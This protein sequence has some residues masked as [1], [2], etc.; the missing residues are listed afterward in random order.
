M[1]ALWWM[2]CWRFHVVVF[3]NRD[4]AIHE[5]RIPSTA[6]FLNF[7]HFLKTPLLGEATTT[8]QTR[9]INGLVDCQHFRKDRSD[10]NPSNHFES[11]S[12]RNLY[13]VESKKYRKTLISVLKRFVGSTADTAADWFFV[14]SIYE[15]ED[16]DEE[17]GD[18]ER[19]RLPLYA[20]AVLGLFT[21][22]LSCYI[23]VMRILQRGESTL[24]K[25]RRWLERFETVC[26]DLPQFVLT[27]MIAAEQGRLTGFAVFNLT[28]SALNFFFGIL[29][30]IEDRLIVEPGDE[31]PYL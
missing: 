6:P 21:F 25:K 5:P 19:F 9:T 23:G 13:S 1:G 31:F 18:I 16:N 22:L 2:L 30:I 10:W 4:S 17:E 8:T 14:Y 12:D 27:S 7:P 11:M 28:T 26:E 3:F 24:V 29:D 20:F 15:I